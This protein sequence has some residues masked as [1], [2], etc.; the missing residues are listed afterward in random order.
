A[1]GMWRYDAMDHFSNS[2]SIECGPQDSNLQPR[3]SS[4]PAFPRGSDYLILPLSVRAE[5]GRPG[6]LGR[7]LLFG[8]TSLVSEPSWP[9]QP[10]Q[11]WLRIAIP[12]SFNRAR[13]RFPAIHP[14]C[15]R[16]LPFGVTQSD[17][18]P[19]LPLS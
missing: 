16:R 14:V 3:D 15:T 7:G 5:N 19:A 12:V 1:S 4:A 6:A 9:T 10:S 11:A 8:L 13:L 18:S 2:K 17:E